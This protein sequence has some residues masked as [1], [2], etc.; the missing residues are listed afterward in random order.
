MHNRTTDTARFGTCSASPEGDDLSPARGILYA[1][2]VGLAFW[3]GMV[4]GAVGA[5]AWA[6]FA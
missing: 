2:I 1:V 5:L 4:L 6:L 3:L